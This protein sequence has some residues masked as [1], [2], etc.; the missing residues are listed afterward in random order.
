[1]LP[2]STRIT[3]DFRRNAPSPLPPG[4]LNLPNPTEATLSNGLRLVVVEDHR[5]PLVSL[6]LA[7]Y[8][9]SVK[10]PAGRQ[11]LTGIMAN[12][13]TEGTKTRRSRQIAEE[14]AL[15][16][17]TL[18]AGSNSDYLTVAA[19]ALSDYSSRIFE[20]LADVTLNPTFPEEELVLAKENTKQGLIQQ[21]AQPSFLASEQTA[22]VLFG[23]HP[24]SVISPTPESID[25]TTQAELL[26]FHRE[27]IVPNR[28]SLIVVGDINFQQVLAEAEKLFGE[29]AAGEDPELKFP[30]PPSIERRSAYVVD[31]PGS[32]QTNIV[33]ANHAI[34]RTD[35]DFFPMLVMHTVLGA[36]ASSRLFMNL[37][38]E[39][40]YTYGAY[41]SLDAR[42][43]GGT[44]RA[45][46]EVRTEV[47]GAAL[48][49]FFY[50]L[51]R[52]R[53]EDVSEKEL[54]DAIAYLTGVFPIR[55]ETQEGLIDQLTQMKMLGLPGDYLHTYREQVA[56]IS[57]AD[58]RRVA[59][60]HVTPDKA[61]IV[62]VGDSAA[63][64]DEVRR[65]SQDVELFDS[66]GN[67]KAERGQKAPGSTV[68]FAGTWNLALKLPTGQSVPA[69]LELENRPDGI[70]G[71]VKSQFGD[72]ELSNVIVDGQSLQ[73]EL[74]MA[75]MGQKTRAEVGAI[76]DG[77]TI[78]GSIIVP[79]FPEIH[80]EGSRA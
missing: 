42:T 15:I 48:H 27:T 36:N 72:A 9:G 29:W 37:R 14:V 32:E 49:E 35:P 43:F 67:R 62:I 70:L 69:T 2:S 6:R 13:L 11:G 61:V 58:I 80:L 16:G 28:A 4:S 66:N 44:F 38:E 71:N 73:G 1:M 64:L 7:F 34:K 5:L 33:I 18:S 17:A 56:A 23:E 8:P 78:K 59:V 68:E 74:S 54:Q 60:E 57:R 39:K 30:A 12:L 46:A 50:E 75:L 26:E 19:S 79:G 22:R 31:R 77:E 65:F 45:S 40:G 20:L 53:N 25:A 21:R 24:Y 63:I 3:E 47:T 51:D 10:D 55:L 41:S 76:I 52:I